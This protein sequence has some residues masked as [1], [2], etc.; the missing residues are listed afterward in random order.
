MANKKDNAVKVEG[1]LY[2]SIQEHCDITCTK[3]GEMRTASCDGSIAAGLFYERGWRATAMN[4]F[5]PKCAKKHLK[6]K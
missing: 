3:C 6:S 4:I 1:L 5:C 2:E